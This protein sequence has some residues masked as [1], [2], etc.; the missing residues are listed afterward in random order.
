MKK[1]KIILRKPES[2][3]AVTCPDCLGECIVC[4]GGQFVDCPTCNGE[5]FIP[6]S[7]KGARK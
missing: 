4:K 1:T 2:F 3:G 6:A 7:S 5:G